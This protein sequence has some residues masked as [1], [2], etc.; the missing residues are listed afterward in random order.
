[1]TYN[2]FPCSLWPEGD[3]QPG[4][5]EH[6]CP[7]V[8]AEFSHVKKN[9]GFSNGEPEVGRILAQRPPVRSFFAITFL[10]GA[11]ILRSHLCRHLLPSGISLSTCPIS[12]KAAGDFTSL[13]FEKHRSKRVSVFNKG[14]PR[15]EKTRTGMTSDPDGNSIY[16]GE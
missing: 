16:L 8:R 5:N 12:H 13:D 15:R 9:V 10:R 4:R 2:C 1:M 6:T 3:E 7:T 14:F 11:N